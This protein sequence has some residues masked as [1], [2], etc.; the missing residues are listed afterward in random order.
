M[1]DWGRAVRVWRMFQRRLRAV[2]T[3]ERTAAKSQAASKVRKAPEIFIL[4]FIMRKACSAGLLV[5]GTEKSTWK[6]KTS[7][8]NSWSRMS[9]LCPGRCF[10]QPRFDGCR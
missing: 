10:V 3:T 4:T 1:R 7:S 2:A 6:R 5:K 8:L 9:R